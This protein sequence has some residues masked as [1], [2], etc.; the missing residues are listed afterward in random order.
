MILISAKKGSE[1]LQ[2][3]S[4]PTD[5]PSLLSRI[6]WTNVLFLT[7]TPALALIFLFLHLKYEAWNWGLWILFAV[8]QFTAGISITGGYHRLFAHRTYE[9]KP[10][11]KLFYLLFGAGAFENS[12]LMWCTDHRRHHR[13]VDQNHDPYNIKRGFFYAHMG[14]IML[15]EPVDSQHEFP[16]DLKEDPL[17]AWQ[18]KCYLWVAVAIGIVLP[19]YLGWMLGSFWGGLAIPVFLRIVLL[20][21]STFL[22]N[23]FCHM[24]GRTTYTDQNSARDSK[25]L[26]FFTLGEGYHNFHHA[27]QSDYRNGCR[28]YHWD[29]TK[30]TIQVM[31]LL[32]CVDKLRKA[33]D[34]KILSA[35]LA[36][37]EKQIRKNLVSLSSQLHLPSLEGVRQRVESAQKRW[38]ELKAEYQKMKTDLSRKSHENL[39]EMKVRL[40]MA[41][42]EFKEAYATWKLYQRAVFRGPLR[43]SSGL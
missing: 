24:F 32:G 3:D 20:H 17:V 22:I 28:W 37:D 34:A 36:M 38:L 19:A 31:H 15:N 13:F 8:F 5:R 41:K 26:A 43:S 12:A 42:M 2:T 30:W 21:H 29:P 6:N 7:S 18:H 16:S 35:R 39:A 1:H 23:S 33:S 27:F 4:R 10:W 40:R 11:V 25:V 14:W 9:A